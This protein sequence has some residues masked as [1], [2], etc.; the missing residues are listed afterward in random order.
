M[1]KGHYNM[2]K[3]HYNK[4]KGHYNMKKGIKQVY[5]EAPQTPCTTTPDYNIKLTRLLEFECTQYEFC[6][7]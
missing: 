5:A 4:K 3:G 1:K 7:A 6:E 2:K